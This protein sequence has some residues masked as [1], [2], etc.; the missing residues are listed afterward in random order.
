MERKRCVCCG[1]L[2]YE[3]RNIH[4]LNYQKQYWFQQKNQNRT[5]KQNIFIIKQRNEFYETRCTLMPNLR[6]LLDTLLEI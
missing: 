3:I 5:K 6:T 4:D 1:I 2:P